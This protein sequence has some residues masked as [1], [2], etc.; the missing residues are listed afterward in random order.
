[1]KNNELVLQSYKY[2]T[3]KL[4]VSQKHEKDENDVR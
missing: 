1:M 3:L 4:Q 2:F